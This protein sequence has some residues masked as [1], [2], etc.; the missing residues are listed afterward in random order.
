MLAT[1]HLKLLFFLFLLVGECLLLFIP[2]AYQHNASY[3]QNNL[4]IWTSSPTLAGT[5]L[6]TGC[7]LILLSSFFS[8]LPG[9]RLISAAKAEWFSAVLQGCFLSFLA[10]YFWVLS[11]GT[12]KK[13]VL[14]M[15]LWIFVV[16]C[17]FPRISSPLSLFGKCCLLCIFW[18]ANRQLINYNNLCSSSKLF[19]RQ[20]ILWVFAK[21]QVYGTCTRIRRGEGKNVET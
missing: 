10:F 12:K 11:S 20:V 9:K 3:C 7:S 14:C 17:T 2:N 15:F 1:R 16:C 8:I 6:T 13:C 4:I 21:V 19:T 18:F 5:P